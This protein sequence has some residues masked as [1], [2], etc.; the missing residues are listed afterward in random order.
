MPTD[1]KNVPKQSSFQRLKGSVEKYTD[2]KSTFLQVSTSDGYI[3]VNITEKGESLA[4]QIAYLI[5]DARDIGYKH[6]Q[7]DMRGMLG[8]ES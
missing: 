7:E 2:N 4:Q 6:A 3:V 8:I 5:E 1:L